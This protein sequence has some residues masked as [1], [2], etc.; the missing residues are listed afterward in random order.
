MWLYSVRTITLRHVRLLNLQ[1]HCIDCFAGGKGM[2]LI[3]PHVY[4]T[5]RR[6]TIL[7]YTLNASTR[8]VVQVQYAHAKYYMIAVQISQILTS[9]SQNK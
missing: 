2:V 7:L 8:V 5:K 3:R 4:S 1:I 6:K 9:F